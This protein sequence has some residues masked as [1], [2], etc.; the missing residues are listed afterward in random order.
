MA[1]RKHAD[2]LVIFGIT[3]DLARK[4]TIKAL[5]RLEAAKRLDVP[6][7][8]VARN[9]WDEKALIKHFRAALR[10]NE[11]KI[12]KAVF[13]RLAR[14]IHYVQATYDDPACYT[15][16]LNTLTHLR[17]KRPVFYLE[18]PPSLFATVVRGLYEV[19]LTKQA[20]F[21]IE[22]PFGH[23]LA[24]ARSLN[25]ELG[26]MLDDSQILRIDHYLGKEP[27]MDI[28]YLRF[29]NT[30]L[31]PVWNRQ[32]V[33]HIT[34]TK[35]ENFGVEDRG[36]FYD[37]VGALRDVVQNHML[38]VLALVTME[39]PAGHGHDPIRESKL[40]LFKAIDNASPRRYV[41]GQYE[42]YQKVDG[43]KRGSK[44]ETYC[45]LELAIDNW[46]W[47]GVPIFI[48]T[49]KAL[50]E[51]A[52]EV[53]VV[54]KKRPRLGHAAIPTGEPNQLVV[55]IE[56]L[57]GAQMRF[58]AKAPGEELPEAVD[59]EVLFEK[60]MGRD[61][62]PYERLLSD[63]IRGDN[64]LFTREEAIEETWRI[65][66]PLLDKPGP[67]HKYK[68]GSWGPAEADKLTR[69]ICSWDTPW[70][71]EQPAKKPKR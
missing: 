19:G 2:A 57:P 9:D 53:R 42:G 37:P 46:R 49:G 67:I 52:T 8:G 41:R 58:L 48:R 50:A 43:V 45:A 55:R 71:P 14:R 17:V 28:T 51:S 33:S 13:D 44:T 69:G 38:Q 24:S 68:R 65:V 1:S 4:Q 27:V 66:Q 15:H 10:E 61:P 35:A 26:E 5:Y 39:P 23:D 7:V 60:E 34:V 40:T 3:G 54:F 62:A 11:V 31:E 63:A 22:K 70:M 29:A 18:I 64:S 56:P 30:L 59:F 36:R 47:S 20:R 25:H 32:Y 6:I 16:V 21:V 12:E